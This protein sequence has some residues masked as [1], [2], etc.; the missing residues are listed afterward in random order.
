MTY[1]WKILSIDGG[2]IRGIVPAVIL[3]A[4]FQKLEYDGIETDVSKIFDL[5][6]GTST[7]GILALG[8]T[9]SKAGATQFRTPADMLNLYKEKGSAIFP[10][11]GKLIDTISGPTHNEQGF[12]QILLDE[13]GDTKL[14][15][16]AT[17][18]LVTSYEIDV[19]APF[20]FKSWEATDSQQDFRIRDVARATSAAPT[21]FAPAK[22]S[23]IAEETKRRKNYKY[24]VDGGVFANNPTLCALA[25]VRKAAS[26]N[27]HNLDDEYLVV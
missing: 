14:S 19:R 24:L 27:A 1:T 4:L 15:Q 11:D 13:F 26:A 25:E 18:V 7:G 12:N 17:N 2:G 3:R 21:Y 5:I 8:L 22:I 6:V 23:S 20:F 16:T 9:T 10:G